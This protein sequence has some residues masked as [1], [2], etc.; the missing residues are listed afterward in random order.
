MRRI[1]DMLGLLLLIHA[2]LLGCA[3]TEPQIKPPKQA[4]EY[5]SPP[6][7]DRRYTGPIEYPKET[8]ESDPLL[9]K[10]AKDKKQNNPGPTMSPTQQSRTGGSSGGF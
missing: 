1:R 10:A 6:D 8:M 7:N 5:N 4:E 3:T 9:K 2:G